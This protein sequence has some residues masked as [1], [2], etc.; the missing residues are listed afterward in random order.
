MRFATYESAPVI[1]LKRLRSNT[2]RRDFD[3]ELL[4]ANTFK[5]HLIAK[6]SVHQACNVPGQKA[7]FFSGDVRNNEFIALIAVEEE[8]IAVFGPIPHVYS[9][10]SPDQGF[11]GHRTR[12]FL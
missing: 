2:D 6:S 4:S 9:I 1:S 10:H 11:D 3:I 8:L 12:T 7:P 5:E